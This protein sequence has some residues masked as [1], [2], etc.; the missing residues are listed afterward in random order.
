MT[1]SG[2]PTNPYARPRLPMG[3]R[4]PRGQIT[5]PQIQREHYRV[6][7]PDQF[8]IYRF[9]SPANLKAAFDALRENGGKAGGSDHVS[10]D[11]LK[12]IPDKAARDTE[13]RLIERRFS[14]NET[15]TKAIR[16]SDGNS[17][18]Y[19]SI[20]NIFPDRTV[21]KALLLCIEP[22]FRSMLPRYGQDIFRLYARLEQYIRENETY[23]LAVDDVKNCFPS[24]DLDRVIGCFNLHI[25]QPDLRWLI[26]R[27]IRGHEDRESASGLDQGSPS[28]PLAMEMYLH[29]CLD[30]VTEAQNPGNTVRMQRYVDNLIFACRSSSEAEE[31]LRM[32]ND[33]L[34]EFDLE[35]K[36]ED[37]KPGDIRDPG[38]NN[39]I[40]GLIP[41]WDSGRLNF[42][43]PDKSFK[44]LKE[45]LSKCNRFRQPNLLAN[46]VITGWT[47]AVGPALTN[48]SEP[49]IIRRMLKICRDTGFYEITSKQIKE[50]ASKA[51]GSWTRLRREI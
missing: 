43:I 4:Q 24:A 18:R 30:S 36:N 51:R 8:D 9:S 14:P 37:G 35:L 32:T 2:Q 28:S 39:H 29:T 23:I 40:L 45:G 46:W 42:R 12:F 19:L 26:N 49:S 20:P 13:A 3:R 21:M 5:S 41:H 47:N 16:K 6:D 34:T 15:R 10:F 38:Y 7:H 11:D 48:K 50:T 25:N 22:Y 1:V 27:I 44:N 17:F 33:V 31:V